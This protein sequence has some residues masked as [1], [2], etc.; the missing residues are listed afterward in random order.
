MPA[1][2]AARKAFAVVKLTLAVGVAGLLT[3]GLL[4]PFV[5]GLGIAARNSVQAFD[6]QPCEVKQT[7]PP[8]ASTVY[9]ADGKTQIARFYSQNREIVPLS[10]I[11][12]VAQKAVVAIEDRRFYEH[13][14]VDV[15]GTIRALI[16]NSRSGGV[17][18]GGSTLTQ[19]YIKQV[20]LYSAKSVAEQ[21]AA[22]E[23]TTARKLIEAKCAL[24]L[25]Q[26][27]SK[28]QILE[29]YLNIAYFGSGAYGIQTAAK[30]Y[31]GKPAAALT[32]P[33]SALLAGIVQSPS[34]FDPH[35]DKKAASARRNTVLDEMQSLGYI[36]AKQNVQAK[37]VPVA[38]KPRRSTVK[39]CANA[40][41]S[42]ANVGFFCDYVKSYLGAI[43]YPRS[44]LETEGLK[45]Y[46][47]LDPRVQNSA[48]AAAMAKVQPEKRATAVMDVI[49][50][51]TGDVRAMA[52]SKYYGN[53]TKDRRQTVLPLPTLAKAGAGST[54]KLFTL[55]AALRQ[56]IP[57]RDFKI[58]VGN[59]YQPS[60]NCDSGG[61]VT[62]V[63]N[64]GHYSDGPWD[65]EQATYAS[66]NTFFVA[67]LDQQMDC[68]LTVP[69]D[70]ATRMGMTAL[71]HKDSKGRTIAEKIK[72]GKEYSFTLGPFG[73]SPLELASAYGTVANQGRYCPPT[74]VER[75]LGADDKPIALPER[76]CSPV[77]DPG[78]ANTVSHVLE[79]DTEPT[80]HGTAQ[81]RF[82]EYYGSGGS[83]V[84]GKTGTASATGKDEG[85]NSAA[86][87]VGLTPNYVGSVA[88]FNP[89]NP[90]SALR[91]IDGFSTGGDV[92]GAFSAGIWVKAMSPILLGG[93]SWQFPPEDPSVVNGNSVPVPSVVGQDVN[94]AT[95][96]LAS[97][98]FGIEVAT[99]RR[100]SPLPP[101]RIADQSPTGRALPG[102]KIIVFLSSGKAP[103]GQPTGP[104][105][106]PSPG[107]PGHRRGPGG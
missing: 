83:P 48:Q 2:T 12:K 25:E 20:R 97:Y 102:Q 89:D 30:T 63:K 4:M 86:W 54:Y 72:Q 37:A 71:T 45:I 106:V 33:E 81:S 14:G 43:G 70:Y 95:Q 53:N 23:Q 68:D 21:K 59:T 78:I 107:P 104:G 29:R 6:D 76:A 47:T 79:K 18:Q 27:L 88:V 55:I 105:G 74:P 10:Q 40:N 69:V 94:T 85:L 84:G 34:R 56:K 39:D 16:E 7:T 8:Q 98:G 32:L 65:L 66:V 92:F 46:T 57:L 93:P 49:D 41:R 44:R 13:H 11:S 75:I 15:Q 38:V 24:T 58:K 22:T 73:T 99:K 28:S 19:Q 82:G 77:L 101:D 87:F 103:T 5:G 51:T 62:P 9:A 36:T 35:R 100:D 31:F 42:I 67:L 1:P 91:D 17:V 3:A 90:N 50:P 96:I 52:V 64:A 61:E 26:E 60:E 80:F